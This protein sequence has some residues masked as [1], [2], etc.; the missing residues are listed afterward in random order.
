MKKT[1]AVMVQ[2]LDDNAIF[3]L[4][5]INRVINLISDEL[6]G[7]DIYTKGD[8]LIVEGKKEIFNNQIT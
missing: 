2:P 1:I 6:R 7:V 3:T 5:R 8:K 4:G